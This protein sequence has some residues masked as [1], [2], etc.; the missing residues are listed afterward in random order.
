MPNIDYGLDLKEA[1]VCP[2]NP[3]GGLLACG[4]PIGATGLMQGVF[5][6]WQLQGAIKKHFCDDRLQVPAAKRG[7]IHSHAGTGTYVTV[8]ALEGEGENFTLQAVIRVK[9]R[10]MFKLPAFV[11][12]R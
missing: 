9:E 10:L 6:L 3:S 12:A 8:S 11:W 7:A 1:P 2:V 5:A 4:H